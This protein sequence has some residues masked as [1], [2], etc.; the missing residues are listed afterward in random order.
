ML[1]TRTIPT[2]LLLLLLLFVPGIVVVPNIQYIIIYRGGKTR[3]YRI[4]GDI[5][6]TVLCAVGAH[7]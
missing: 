1:Y 4:H 7:K 2:Y 5:C 3:R 6:G